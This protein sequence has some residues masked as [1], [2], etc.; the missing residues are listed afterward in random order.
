MSV[1]I[2][3]DGDY[4]ILSNFGRLMNDPKHFDASRDVDEML[5]KG[6]RKFVLELRGVGTLGDSGLGLLMTI[7]RLVRQYGGDVALAAP[8]S[9]MEKLLNDMQMESYWDVFTDVE[10]AKAS[11]RATSS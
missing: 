11:F 3:V 8:S 9:G 4:V 5:A 6:Y 1:H 7:T 10:K 2:R